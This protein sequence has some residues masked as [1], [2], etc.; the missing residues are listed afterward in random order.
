MV[1][2]LDGG[3]DYYHHRNRQGEEDGGDGVNDDD[4]AGYFWTREDFQTCREAPTAP[5]FMLKFLFEVLDQMWSSAELSARRPFAGPPIRL[6]L[7]KLE[8]AVV[9]SNKLFWGKRTTRVKLD[10][11][12]HYELQQHKSKWMTFL[13]DDLTPWLKDIE[14]TPWM[15]REEDALAQV[16]Y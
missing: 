15:K 6:L 8:I 13:S 16:W 4:C 2:E 10:N 14:N 9:H 3:H 5:A 12:M 11:R 7:Q 1:Q